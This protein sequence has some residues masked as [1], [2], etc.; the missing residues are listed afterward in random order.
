MTFN[1]LKKVWYSD[2]YRYQGRVNMKVILKLFI[3]YPG[4]TYS[5]WLRLCS[6]L[7]DKPKIFLPLYL[8]CRAILQR[9]SHKYGIEISPRTEIGQGLQIY[10]F[11][12]IV[13]NGKAK[14]GK[15]LTITQGVTIGQSARGKTS[16]YPTIGNNVYIAPGAMV[17]G[18]IE[19]GNYVAIGANCVLTKTV[20]DNAVVVGIPGQIISHKGSK[21]Y[22]E[23][24]Y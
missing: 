10:H 24:V 5:F 2:A 4:F 15:N 12:G 13:I 8:I 18:G 22:V 6:Y 23:N 21:S 9:Y 17:L 1:D 7:L 19:V 16:G 11:G 14:I 3:I 20:P